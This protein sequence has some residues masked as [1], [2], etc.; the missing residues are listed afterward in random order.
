MI[1]RSITFLLVLIAMLVI[2]TWRTAAAQPYDRPH[3]RAVDALCGWDSE[4]Y[5]AR[6]G[7]GLACLARHA[8]RLGPGC[9][10]ALRIAAILDG[11]ELDYRRWCAD[12]PPGGG[13]LAVCLRANADR[14][15]QTCVRALRGPAIRGGAS[16]LRPDGEDDEVLRGEWNDQRRPVK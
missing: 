16:V 2:V 9:Y 14:L 3:H 13:R 7:D 4:R 8:E 5:C 15:S 6:A 11:C 12:V 1:S 10:R